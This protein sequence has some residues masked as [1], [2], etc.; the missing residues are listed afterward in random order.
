MSLSEKPSDSIGKKTTQNIGW[1]YLSFGLSKALSLLIISILAHILPPENFGLVALATLA[2]DYLSVVGD[3]GLGSALVQLR[4]NIDEASDTVFSINLITGLGLSTLTFIVAPFAA[5]FF[6]EPELVPVLRWLGLSF[7]LSA[8][9]AVH[10]V[11]LQRALNFR[12]KLIP[13]LGNSI[14]KGIISITMAL[15][16]FGVWSL[17]IGQLV[18]G[19]IAS[20]LLWVVVPWRP[21]LHIRPDLAGKL[22]SFGLVIML[23]NALAILGDSF[24]YLV[25]GR[26]FNTAALGVYTLA[27][28]LPELLVINTLWVMTAVLFPAFSEIQSDIEMLRTNFLKVIRYVEMIVVPLCL[29]MVVAADPIIRVFFGE[30]W[31]EAI[32]IMRVLSLYALVTSIGFHVGDVYKA[33]GRPDILLKIA[34]PVFSIRIL[35]LWIGAQYSLLGVAI[36]HLVSTVIEVTIRLTV[37]TRIVKISPRAILAQLRALLAGAALIVFA[38]GALFIMRSAQ[39][40]FQ[41]IFIIFAGATGYILAISQL[42]KEILQPIFAYASNLFTPKG[43]EGA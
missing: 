33:I 20:L 14:I 21:R 36:A 32:P 38:L 3:L 41:L 1:N 40:I 22:F 8:I 43:T 10:N 18:G 7:T 28:R 34:I 11:R 24:D 29:G 23:N 19:G 15:S 2:I 30:Q 27:Y 6:R 5:T 17:V 12:R 9:G 39:P 37:A 31:L 35:A 26:V 4:G 42:E 25:I 13:D 16:G